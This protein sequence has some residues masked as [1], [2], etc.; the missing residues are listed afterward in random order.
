MKQR[1]SVEG[2]LGIFVGVDWGT[3]FHRA[4]VLDVSGEILREC[5][6]DH[7]GQAITEFLHS[8]QGLTNGEPGRIAVAIEV[9]RGPV[10][11]A[12][13]EGGF[14]VFSINPKQLDRFRD[15]HTPAGAKDDSRDAYVAADSLR[16]D[17]HCFR[18]IATDHPDV[19]RLRELSRTEESLGEDLRRTVNQLYQLLL[20]YYPQLLQLKS[21][22]D[23]G[24]TVRTS[25]LLRHR[26]CAVSFSTTL[27]IVLQASAAAGPKN[28]LSTT[29]Q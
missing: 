15:R 21:A 13:L 1:R 22:P 9:P 2:E 16:T 29:L 14:A 26:L 5:R 17:Q 27:A 4:C 19:V 3:E 20:R 24:K 6:I 8:L 25:L 11:E 28:S 12:F 10:V 7:N 23:G 18:C